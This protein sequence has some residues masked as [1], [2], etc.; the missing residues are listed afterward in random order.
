MPFSDNKMIWTLDSIS[1]FLLITN[2]AAKNIYV[3]H[4]T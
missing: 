2:N 3:G 4:H 1:K